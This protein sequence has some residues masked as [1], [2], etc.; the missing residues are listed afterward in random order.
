MN[1]LHACHQQ[2]P[3]SCSMPSRGCDGSQ[4]ASGHPKLT[5]SQWMHAGLQVA[6]LDFLEADEALDPKL[7]EAAQAAG[8][9]W[10]QSLCYPMLAYSAV[11]LVSKDGN[12]ALPGHKKLEAFAQRA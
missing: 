3:V 6:P 5:H 7:L 4:H 2:Q 10:T 12:T 1:E 9:M 11:V 8:T